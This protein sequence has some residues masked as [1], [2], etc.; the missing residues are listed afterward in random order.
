[1]QALSFMETLI[2]YLSKF[3]KQNKC[4]FDDMWLKYM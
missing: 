2:V 3:R 4:N 1:M